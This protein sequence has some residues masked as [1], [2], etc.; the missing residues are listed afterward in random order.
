MDLGPCQHSEAP[1]SVQNNTVTT[2]VKYKDNYADKEYSAAGSIPW[3]RHSSS[4]GDIEKV[5]KDKEVEFTKYNEDLMDFA[6]RAMA[7]ELAV[8][9]QWTEIV[10]EAGLLLL[11]PT[12]KVPPI[13][14][15]RI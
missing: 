10:V 13:I 14:D 9:D 15:V 11:P 5:R 4:D 7:N 12:P 1:P 2:Y 6:N 3:Y 8:V